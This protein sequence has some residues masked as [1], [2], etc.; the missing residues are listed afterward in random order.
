MWKKHEY[1]NL[2][3]LVFNAMLKTELLRKLY[4]K[5]IIKLHERFVTDPWIPQNPIETYS[6]NEYI[7]QDLKRTKLY[8]C[9]ANKG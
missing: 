4:T 9:V 1:S 5:Y 6:V 8:F 2:I 3:L 7:N